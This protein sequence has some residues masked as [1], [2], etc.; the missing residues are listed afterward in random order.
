VI[1]GSLDDYDGAEVLDAKEGENGYGRGAGGISLE[2][3][4]REGAQ[5][6]N[7]ALLASPEPAYEEDAATD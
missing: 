4:L 6:R 7:R 3:T 5:T 1:S 2:T